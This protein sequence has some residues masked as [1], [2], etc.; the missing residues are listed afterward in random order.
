MN[1]RDKNSPQAIKKEN[2]FVYMTELAQQRR[3]LHMNM[4]SHRDGSLEANIQE[5]NTGTV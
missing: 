2:T 1:D 4:G 3:R 5:K